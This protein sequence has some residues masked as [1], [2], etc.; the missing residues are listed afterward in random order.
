[1]KLFNFL[2]PF[3][4]NPAQAIVIFS[5]AAEPKPQEAAVMSGVKY[6]LQYSI[7]LGKSRFNTYMANYNLWN[8]CCITVRYTGE[9]RHIHYF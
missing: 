7:V 3:S 1:V 6:A 8:T 2:N 5:S 4:S 9:N